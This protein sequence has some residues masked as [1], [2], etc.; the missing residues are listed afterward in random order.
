MPNTSM[1]KQP[2]EFGQWFRKLVAVAVRNGY[3][4]HELSPEGWKEYFDNGYSP[5][6]AWEES[7]ITEF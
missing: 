5:E 2:L 6:R 3:Q 1:R 7:Q 4:T